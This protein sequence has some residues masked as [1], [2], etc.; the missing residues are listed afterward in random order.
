VKTNQ[1]KKVTAIL[2]VLLMAF[3][4]SLLNIFA[5]NTESET[6]EQVAA[7]IGSGSVAAGT[8]VVFSCKTDGVFIMYS[9]NE[10]EYEEYNAAEQI[11]LDTFPICL[12]AY[13]TK[14]GMNSDITTFNYTKKEAMKSRLLQ[15]KVQNQAGNLD[16]MIKLPEKK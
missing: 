8:S 1:L 7:T 12:K 3:N 6:I 2:L 15:T 16:R 9:I 10:G 5:E 4:F 11:V 13:A 14:D